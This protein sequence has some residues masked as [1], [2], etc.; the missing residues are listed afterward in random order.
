MDGIE[1][2]VHDFE[3][4][5]DHKSANYRREREQELKVVGIYMEGDDLTALVLGVLIDGKCLRGT[6]KQ[7]W[8]RPEM[9]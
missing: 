6:V 1:F 2:E 8:S 3:L 9:T 5:R 4:R 7:S